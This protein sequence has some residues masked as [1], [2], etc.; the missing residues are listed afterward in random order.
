MRTLRPALVIPIHCHPFRAVTR[1]L[2]EPIDKLSVI[3]SITDKATDPIATS[4]A[5]LVASDG[6]H[7][8]LV[9]G[10]AEYDGT[11][12]EHGSLN[13]MQCSLH[14]TTTSC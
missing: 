11:D 8:E 2:N 5:T 3:A 6:K 1:N 13:F 4:P 10:V 14:R 9:G 7:I 12:A